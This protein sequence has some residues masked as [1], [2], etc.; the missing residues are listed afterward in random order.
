MSPRFIPCFIAWRNGAGSAAA[1]WKR[2][3]NAGGAIIGSPPR[4]R[5]CWPNNALAGSSLSPPSD[6][7]PE[8]SMLDWKAE[9]RRRLA[10][11]NLSPTRELEIVEEVAQHLE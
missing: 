1:G 8:L 5:R 6:E 11:L 9:I 2:Q 4:E 3:D 10:G 7:S